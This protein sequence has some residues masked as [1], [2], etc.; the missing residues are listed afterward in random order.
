MQIKAGFTPAKVAERIEESGAGV[1]KGRQVTASD[2]GE[3]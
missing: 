1:K 3:A 2:P